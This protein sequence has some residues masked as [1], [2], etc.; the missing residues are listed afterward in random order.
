MVLP[1]LHKDQIDES[2]LLG[3]QGTPSETDLLDIKTVS[4]TVK[5]DDVWKPEICEDIAAF[6]NARGGLIILGMKEDATGKVG[7]LCGLGAG[8]NV[9]DEIKRLKQ[10]ADSGIVPLVLG[11]RFKPVRLADPTKAVAIVIQIPRGFIAPHKVV[12]V[13]QGVSQSGQIFKIR[14]SNGNADMSLD[15]LRMAFNLA[16]SY[17]EQVRQFRRDRVSAIDDDGSEES[18]VPLMSGVRF[19]MHLVP[20]AFSEIDDSVD[21]SVL[22]NPI[23]GPNGV[24]EMGYAHTRRF[25]FDGVFALY[26]NYHD[27]DGGYQEYMQAFRSGAIEFVTV[28]GNHIQEV[29]KRTFH[30]AWIER[31]ALEH[32]K[33]ALRISQKISVQPPLAIMLSILGV[34]GFKVMSGQHGHVTGVT[35]TRDWL[36]LPEVLVTDYSEDLRQVLKPAF[37]I[38]WNAGGWSG[39]GSYD[40]QGKWINTNYG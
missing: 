35:I 32:I 13:R 39:S 26:G 10:V 11:L 5:P 20:V 4:Y 28:Y 1:L 40:E 19:V 24:I 36:L 38:V 14:H 31:D 23:D 22:L 2:D 3:L 27:A 30:G 25:N 21:L 9:D 15:E 7:E 34:Q 17:V 16:E 12:R 6:A 37:D 29:A 33:R 8:L 18:F